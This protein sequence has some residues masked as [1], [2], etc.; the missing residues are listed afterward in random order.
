MSKSSLAYNIVPVTPFAQNCSVI[1]CTNTKLAAVVD[2]GGEVEKIRAVIEENQ[3]EL[4]KIFITHAHLD[5]AG[6]TAELARATG[7]PIIGPHKGDQFWID[8]LPEQCQRFGF[9]GEIFTPDQWLEHGDRLS[10][11]ELNFDVI[12]CPG[13]TPG[14]VV[15]VEKSEQFAAVGDVIFQGSIGRS[16]FPQGNQEHLISSIRDRLFPIGDEIRFI[17]GHGPMSTFGAERRNNAF[18][19]DHRFG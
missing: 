17:P 7:V 9:E 16:D 13:H 6:G 8:A 10:L 4:D 11:G 14:H 19:A 15:F 3:L 1:W 18:V 12:H 5:H 2:P